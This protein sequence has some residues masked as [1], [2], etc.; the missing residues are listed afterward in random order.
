MPLDPSNLRTL[1]PDEIQQALRLVPWAC[2]YCDTPNETPLILWHT[3]RYSLI[4]RECCCMQ[5]YDRDI[6]PIDPAPP[7]HVRK[8]RTK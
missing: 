5:N 6:S 2:S 4:C 7:A 3:V 8:R 1:S